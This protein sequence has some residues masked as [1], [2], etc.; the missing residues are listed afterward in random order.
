VKSQEKLEHEVGERLRA[1]DTQGAASRVI[2]RCGP[3]VLGYLRVAIGDDR[4]AQ[5]AFSAFETALAQRLRRRG[6]LPLHVLAYQLA[7]RCAKQQRQ[8]SQTKAAATR[9]TARGA[10]KTKARA[11]TFEPLG[12]AEDAERLRRELSL[13]DQT[14]LT[15]RLARQFEW[16][17][18]AAVLVAGERAEAELLIR[19]RYQ[20]LV[21]RL[22]RTAIERGLIESGPLPASLTLVGGS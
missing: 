22:H 9:D 14:L 4:R 20:R 5:A 21:V 13:D 17:D 6:E 11:A 16:S 19:R 3:G 7:Y 15:L 1:G 12:A 2:R 10:T 8:A 18:I